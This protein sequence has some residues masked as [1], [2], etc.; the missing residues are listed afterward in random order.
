MYIKHVFRKRVS[1]EGRMTAN[2]PEYTLRGMRLT[3]SNPFRSVKVIMT[4]TNDDICVNLKKRKCKIFYISIVIA[5]Y[6][7]KK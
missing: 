4:S 3:S 6:E 7:I 1:V 5:I 2:I